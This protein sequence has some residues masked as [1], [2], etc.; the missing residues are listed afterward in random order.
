MAGLLFVG[1][2]PTAMV[3]L[4]KSAGGLMAL[5]YI[6]GATFQS[7]MSHYDDKLTLT[8]YRFFIGILGATFV[9]CQFWS[10]QMFAPKVVGAANALTG[11]W[12]NMGAGIT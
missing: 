11:G 1:A 2:I 10:T 5:R 4:V 7:N 12:G 6:D 3:G 8:A 9:P